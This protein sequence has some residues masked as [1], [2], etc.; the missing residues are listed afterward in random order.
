MVFWR[1]KV[2]A[3]D[4]E[5]NKI[6]DS[7]NVNFA[8]VIFVG[9]YI[10]SIQNEKKDLQSGLFIQSVSSFWDEN[11]KKIDATNS[12]KLNSAIGGQNN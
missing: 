10:Y 5:Q 7:I 2:I 8:N 1:S 4:I 3:I 11:L 12:F 9:N 6:L